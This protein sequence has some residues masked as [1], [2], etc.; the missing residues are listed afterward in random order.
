MA[1]GSGSTTSYIADMKI[2]IS[3]DPDFP[4]YMCCLPLK[5]TSFLT[6]NN[7]ILSDVAS[8]GRLL[9]IFQTLAQNSY[10]FKTFADHVE[11]VFNGEAT[12]I[13]IIDRYV[14][15]AFDWR[16]DAYPDG[17]QM[18]AVWLS[19]VLWEKH[20]NHCQFAGAFDYQE[21]KLQH[22]P[23]CMKFIAP[24]QLKRA[25]QTP[26]VEVV[27]LKD[28]KPAT[29]ESQLVIDDCPHGTPTVGYF[30]E[31]ARLQ[32]QQKLAGL[33]GFD[34]LWYCLTPDMQAYVKSKISQKSR[35]AVRML[36]CLFSQ[37]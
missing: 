35:E 14:S 22:D 23:K 24:R 3:A 29:C 7:C 18:I 2:D 25:S 30:R 26:V 27:T 9:R 1:A 16:K 10:N 5:I 20:I 17:F 6:R 33:E 28:D 31:T 12:F 36:D 15:N 32:V 19:L 34:D 21:T 8:R 13:A 4:P 37:E 11:R